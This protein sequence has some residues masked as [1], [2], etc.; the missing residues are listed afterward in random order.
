MY[1]RSERA[2]AFKAKKGK[3]SEAI[4]KYHDLASWKNVAYK[5]YKIINR[6]L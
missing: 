2:K 3:K 1:C 4:Q 6:W 5:E